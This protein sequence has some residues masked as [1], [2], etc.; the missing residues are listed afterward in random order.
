MEF[1][2]DQAKSLSNQAKHGI[3]FHEAQKLW[4]DPFRVVIPAITVDEARF[5]I[6]ATWSSKLWT[7][8]FTHRGTSTRIISVRRARPEE[9]ELYESPGF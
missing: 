8:I 3:S 2:F 9:K 1:E 6:V 4:D 5:A 7:E